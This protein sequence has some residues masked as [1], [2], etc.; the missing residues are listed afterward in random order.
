MGMDLAKN[1]GL[2]D[3]LLSRFDLVF[4]VRDLTTEEIDRRIAEQVVRQAS[5]RLGSDARRGVEQVHS[6]ILQRREEADQRN[7][8]EACEVF[9]RAIPGPNGA[10][11]PEVL[12]VDFLRKYIRFCRRLTP[13]LTEEA[14]AMVSEK[15]VDMRMRFQSGLA[16]VSNPESN[17]KPRLAVTTRTLEALIRLSTAHAKLK[18]RKDWVLPEDVHEAYRLMMGAREEDIPA[19]PR[20]PVTGGGGGGGGAPSPS[21]S[22]QTKKGRK[23]ARQEATSASEFGDEAISPGRVNTLTLLV[24]RVFGNA[25]TQQLKRVEL[26]EGVNSGLIEGEQVFGEEEFDAGLAVMEARN[27]ILSLP[28]AGEVMLVG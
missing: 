17:K 26:L 5:Q 16:D 25:G 15:Y 6:S 18:L 4:V 8:Q 1:I 27:K 19:A 3:S 12:T 28:H 23:R 7:S 24:A 10:E 13:V 11:P 2:P 22:P 21:A 9:E 20:A 14:Q